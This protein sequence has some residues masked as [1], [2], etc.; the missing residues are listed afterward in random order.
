MFST[1]SHQSAPLSIT[2]W[3]SNHMSAITETK[4]LTCSFKSHA[5]SNRAVLAQNKLFYN[6]TSFKWKN[7]HQ[8]FI[9]TRSLELVS[10]AVLSPRPPSQWAKTWLTEGTEIW[11]FLSEFNTRLYIFI[12]FFLFYLD[13]LFQT[14][15]FQSTGWKFKNEPPDQERESASLML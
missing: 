15:C 14:D 4:S 6:T 1:R 12:Q 2:H 5:H 7:I 13:W 11:H 10:L 3:N 8:Y 9:L